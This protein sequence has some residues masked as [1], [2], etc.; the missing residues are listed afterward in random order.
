MISMDALFGLPRKKSAGQSHR[1]PLHG[2]IFF[3]DQP[4]VD[5]HVASSSRRNA[6]DKVC[7]D[8]LAGD[9]LRSSN[10]YKALD[11]TALFG[12]ACR[13]EFPL[14]F[15]NLKHGERISY[16]EWLLQEMVQSYP[17][18]I[19]LH[20]MYD[21]A[22]TLNKYMQKYE[23][24]NVLLKKVQL[25]LPIFHA[26]G[27]K[28]QCQIIFSPLRCDGLGLSDGEVMERLW[29]FLRRFSRMTKEMRPAH[30]TDVLC[31]A[32]IYYGYKTKRKLG[33]LLLNRW[34]K[35]EQM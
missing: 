1:D 25:C 5:E 29:S 10:R 28:P 8:F 14:M 22:C 6:C 32:L 11:E 7:S 26:Y 2:H 33:S 19:K 21:I 18:E 15:I 16:A 23:G 9:V 35:A 13:H 17:A 27:H 31:H 4:S 12:C 30:R 20:V 3:K 34:K 24:N